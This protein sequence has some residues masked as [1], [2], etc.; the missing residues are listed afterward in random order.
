[1]NMDMVPGQKAA[2]DIAVDEVARLWNAWPGLSLQERV[3]AHEARRANVISK[4]AKDVGIAWVS[5]ALRVFEEKNDIKWPA[6]P[7]PTLGRE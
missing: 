2:H 6:Y 7:E 4:T 1:M 3:A 5:Y